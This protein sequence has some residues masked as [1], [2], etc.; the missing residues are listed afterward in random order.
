[1]IQG[2]SF[3]IISRTGG[4]GTFVGVPEGHRLI[5]FK[6]AGLDA[7]ISYVGGTGDDVTVEID[8]PYTTMF[9][10]ALVTI[11][12]VTDL[13]GS[14]NAV[15]ASDTNVH[16]WQSFYIEVY[17]QLSSNVVHSITDIEFTLDFDP[18]L[19]VLD[20]PN[21]QPG[22][23]ITSL[24]H[25]PFST[26]LIISGTLNGSDPSFGVGRP[27]LIAR[28]PA[29]SIV[30]A[31]TS[32]EY[33]DESNSSLPVMNGSEV[34]LQGVQI[35]LVGADAATP[36]T[37]IQAVRYDLND[38]DRVDLADLLL[39]I[40]TF[41]QTTINEDSAYRADFDESGNVGLLDLLKMINHFGYAEGDGNSIE[42]PIALTPEPIGF[43][44]EGQPIVDKHFADNLVGQAVPDVVVAK[45]VASSVF[46]SR[47]A[48]PDL[49][50]A[51][52]TI[53]PLLEAE[54][55]RRTSNTHIELEPVADFQELDA[56]W[57]AEY[58]L[59]TDDEQLLELA[60]A[61]QN[62]SGTLASKQTQKDQADDLFAEWGV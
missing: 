22:G 10:M 29:D 38:N 28:I 11:P 27:F 19:I 59:L 35:S 18:S 21:I 61:S 40:Q 43:Q 54:P 41:G 31:N 20:L 56:L 6:G 9:D 49:Q 2:D 16:E 1:M 62:T 13:D 12:T 23:G 36:A 52:F 32:G 44:L 26:Q 25:Q 30:N 15:P 14:L 60:A 57:S 46:N 8:V 58:E 42:F 7:V 51:N 48:Q 50:N 45:T 5:N 39:L 33:P 17:A 55:I 53:T 34:S 3:T 37:T 24:M 47:Q 4:T